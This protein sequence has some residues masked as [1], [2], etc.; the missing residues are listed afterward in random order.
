MN[1]DKT[2]PILALY[3]D[4]RNK[5]E[6]KYG[7]NTIILM[8]VGDFFEIYSKQKDDVLLNNTKN[9]LQTRIAEKNKDKTTPSYFMCGFPKHVLY[10]KLNV[11]LKHNFTVVVV[12]QLEN[13]KG[14]SR[15]VTE[16]HTPGISFTNLE[17]ENANH[18]YVC[19][20]Y[21][22]QS[23]KYKTHEDILHIGISLI[24]ISTGYNII[25]E[26]LDFNI[27][28]TINELSQF[29]NKF[30]PKRIMLYYDMVEIKYLNEIKIIITELNILYDEI[31]FNSVGSEKSNKYSEYNKI[32]YQDAFFNKIFTSTGMVSAIEYFNI[33]KYE[34]AIIS[35]LL[36]LQF[37]HEYNS[38]IIENILDPEI[39]INTNY[40]NFNNN[41]LYQLNITE[42]NIIDTYGTTNTSKNSTL[43][44]IINKTS[45]LM[46]KRLLY[47]RMLNPILDTQKLNK[48][49]DQIDFMIQDNNY[50]KF[51]EHL[52]L[53]CDIERYHRK[54][55]MEKLHPY[56]FTKLFYSFKSIINIL[57]LVISTSDDSTDETD[58]PFNHN[59]EYFNNFKE[60][61][62]EFNSIFNDID[63]MENIKLTTIK[64]SF[65][66]KGTNA[67]I[68][69]LQ[70][71]IDEK[72]NFF[73]DEQQKLS[74]FIDNKSNY[75]S[76]VLHNKKYVLFATTKRCKVMM[77]GFNKVKIND[78]DTNTNK[79]VYELIKKTGNTSIISS[80]KLTLMSSK[81]I[82]LESSI[83]DI[84]KNEFINT[85]SFQYKKFEQSIKYIT[86]LISIID[87]N[88]SCAKT[89]IQNVYHKPTIKPYNNDNIPY[90]DCENIRHPIIERLNIGT[91][92]ITNDVRLGQTKEE[93]D[94][95]T[96][97]GLIL[98]GLNAAGKSS[99]MKAIGLNIILAQM[100]MYVPSSKFEYYP[101]NSLYTRI[102]D[103]DNIFKGQSSFAVEMTELNYI[104]NYA[105]EH[106]LVIGDEVCKGTETISGISLV[107]STI[108]TLANNNVKFIFASHLHQLTKLEEINSIDNIT[109]N[110][111]SV[112]YN[113]DNND[114]AYNRKLKNGP[115][116]DIYGL[117]VA[118]HIINN[119]K[120]LSFA[121]QIRNKIQKKSNNILDSN[122]S[123]Y[124]SSIYVNE[125]KICKTTAEQVKPSQLDVHHINQQKDTDCNNI[126]IDKH[127]HKNNSHNL[128]VL[129]KP[130]HQKVHSNKIELS[131]WVFTSNG[132]QLNY[133]IIENIKIK[134]KKEVND[135][136]KE[137]EENK[138]N[139]S[140]IYNIVKY[141]KKYKIVSK[142]IEKL[143]IRK[144]I[145]ISSYFLK[146]ILNE[147]N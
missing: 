27:N 108:N 76:I 109:F 119:D 135:K 39:Y 123:K 86:N 90:I 26:L 10:G 113:T 12:E 36:L 46:G 107:T 80:P 112:E 87:I 141:Y 7:S 126:V 96:H 138:Y 115:G 8:Q 134:V 100:G 71:K 124:N 19:C 62:N 114:I 118:R 5:Y 97:D 105:D 128:V 51:E 79:T 23:K 130:C 129:C 116:P 103:N 132:I 93:E 110:H 42:N 24:D 70:D 35:Y 88:K 72:L 101:F 38:K 4:Y 85:L 74:N 142:T 30:F 69:K 17:K 41:A 98:F 29:I 21:I 25:Y 145:I 60:Y 139:E 13:C 125:C 82:E 91:E 2:P 47:K 67:K 45:T 6:K 34:F 37:T 137:K 104:I 56:E 3:Y 40:L 122:S 43:F 111:L 146:K 78:N 121:Q 94:K 131:G 18:D 140:E 73:N 61:Y 52:N 55:V 20:F 127:F 81:L 77:D 59:I 49:Y 57:D 89:S 99:F 28:K 92:Y 143:K 11:F 32:A 63:N 50:L 136:D 58:T 66:T 9:I 95:K 64:N 68:D 31:D 65:F 33:G 53:V 102:S 1:N 75:V 147:H 106:S 15:D 16:I 44:K 54:I 48:R 117:E 84:V 144:N 22:K 83:G 120:F 14:A 133:K